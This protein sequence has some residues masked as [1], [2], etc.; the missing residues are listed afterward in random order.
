M[1]HTDFAHTLCTRILSVLF[2]AVATPP[3]GRPNSEDG[4]VA[5]AKCD[6]SY[7]MCLARWMMWSLDTW[8]S[9]STEDETD[10]RL[11]RNIT[12]SLMQILGHRLSDTP[13]K[14]NKAY[15][16]LYLIPLVI[17]LSIL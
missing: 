12:K 6:P 3:S 1:L 11:R 15:A 7:H 5:E 4:I 2:P 13:S 17:N 16:Q 9:T 10:V 8:S 14:D